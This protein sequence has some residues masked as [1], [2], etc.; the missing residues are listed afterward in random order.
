MGDLGNP[1]AGRGVAGALGDGGVGVLIAAL[2]GHPLELAGGLQLV[3]EGDAAALDLAE[4]FAHELYRVRIGIGGEGGDGAVDLGPEVAGADG[5]PV[6]LHGDAGFPAGGALAEQIVVGQREQAADLGGAVELIGGG[7]AVGAEARA[8]E[9][10]VLP[11]FARDAEAG[12]EDVLADVGQRL[13]RGKPLLAVEV[14]EPVDAAGAADGPGL[15]GPEQLGVNAG[16]ALAV[17]EIGLRLNAG[18]DDV[19]KSPARTSWVSAPT[20]KSSSGV[21]GLLQWRTAPISSSGVLAKRLRTSELRPGA[22]GGEGLAVVL[23]GP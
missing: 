17:V 21:M 3:V 7:G 23:G 6:L 19:S 12:I 8:G 15:V 16:L 2:E 5:A 9:G 18:L 11:E 1:V 10:E 13:D 14:G 4:I 22:D 20:R